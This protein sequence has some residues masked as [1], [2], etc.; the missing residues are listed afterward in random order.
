M[1]RSPKELEARKARR[2]MLKEKG[3]CVNECGRPISLHFSSLCDQ[4]A[5][6]SREDCQRRRSSRTKEENRVL[7]RKYSKNNKEKR[8]AYSRQYYSDN[9]E[10]LRARRKPCSNKTKEKTR[11]RNKKIKE[12]RARYGICT[13]CG[14]HQRRQHSETCEKCFAKR[15]TKR[16]REMASSKSGAYYKERKAAGVCSRGCGRPVTEKVTCEICLK[17]DVARREDL[18]AKGL[19]T[20]QCGSRAEI[21]ITMCLPCKIR[22]RI[23]ISKNAAKQKGYMPMLISPADLLVWFKAKVVSTDGRC[24]WCG[25]LFMGFPTIDHDHE[26]GRAHV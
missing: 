18:K 15:N 12:E 26:I 10:S 9:K 5:K 2:L 7:S 13:D 21:G 3:L 19:C 1:P 6:K 17:K 20:R 8:N 23:T 24:E 4:C 16:R 25:D 11:T 14:K 22:S